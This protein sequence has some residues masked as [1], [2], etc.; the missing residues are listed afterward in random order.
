MGC[1]RQRAAHRQKVGALTRV[2]GGASLSA[3]RRSSLR[4]CCGVL[5]LCGLV[6]SCAEPQ[7]G[8]SR[9]D[10]EVRIGF[11]E[12]N[13]PGEDL[14]IGQLANLLSFESFTNNGFDGRA[15]PRLAASWSW[16]NDDRTLRVQ[17][18][19]HVLVHDGRPFTSQVAAEAI[20]LAVAK[21]GNLARYP[22]LAEIRAARPVGESELLIDVA[23][24]SA[25]LPEDLTVPLDLATGPY[26]VVRRTPIVQLERF[27]HYYAGR[28]NFARVQ[29]RPFDTLRTTWANLLRGEVDIVADVP[30]DAVEFIRS[31]EVDVVPLKRWYQYLIAFNSR[32]G[33]L[34]SPDVRRALNLA[35][36]RE[37]LVS[38]VL[39]GRGTP[40]SGPFWPEYW[41]YDKAVGPY[42]LDP[43]LSASL[44]D[45]AGYRVVQRGN[46]PPSRFSFTL[47]VPENFAVWER[48]ALEVQR[49]LFNVGVD[50]QF[51]VVPF[52]EFNDL[53]GK[54]E[55]EAVLLDS[56]SGPTPGR[57]YIFWA[58]ARRFT[59]SYN[60]FGY[61]NAE[62]E[63]LFER[64]RTTRNEAAVRSATRRLQRVL[65]DDPPALFLAWNERARAIRRDFAIPEQTG[66][67]PMLSLWQWTRRPDIRNISAE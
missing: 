11:P 4:G 59:G 63:A 37:L 57:A 64:L 33:P 50:M 1:R 2:P 29:I 30:G 23:R 26:R 18:R 46:G 16:E 34:A 44:F 47:L 21:R 65:L 7:T 28:P 35:I 49:S 25:L 12:G 13:V 56:I 45:G 52:A 60:L 54:G 17:L 20:A 22:A 10:E 41:A 3:K 39:Q 6:L 42:P 48:I 32:R 14:G 43:S 62:A 27:D 8:A 19:P 67:D 38:E 51:K 5:L 15:T 61:E 58:S 53:I 9:D 36:D 31:D 40:S 24:E 55:F 66:R